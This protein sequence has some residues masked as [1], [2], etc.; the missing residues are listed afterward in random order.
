MSVTMKR[1]LVVEDDDGTR[2]LLQDLLFS[3]GYEVSTATDGPEA[4]SRIQRSG[5]PNLALIDLGLPTM[6][7][8]TLCE[9]IK[10]MGDVPI[11][12]LTGEDS[13]EAIV[14]AIH[15]YADDYITKPFN[16]REVVARI[17]RVLS[18]FPD[19]ALAEAARV[20]VDDY[21]S[22]DLPNSRIWRGGEEISLTPTESNILFILF[23]N[24]GRT[25]PPET[26]MAR[27]W[28]NEEVFEETLRVHLHRLRRKL[29][30]DTNKAQYIH[31]ERGTGYVF[32][33]PEAPTPNESDL[34]AGSRH[35]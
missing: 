31:T 14:F 27:V 15:R 6:H 21:L 24:A 20:P 22:I 9:R 1:I 19:S 2:A 25:I 18:R 12:I 5:L 7:G 33:T 4:L 30:P 32:R 26:L 35:S 29:Q 28:P 16:R 11:I 23:S 8:F 10:R 3:A 34:P 13:E 17:Q